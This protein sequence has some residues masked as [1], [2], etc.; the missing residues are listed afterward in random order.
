MRLIDKARDSF[1]GARIGASEGA[2]KL[3]IQADMAEES[4]I[5][6]QEGAGMPEVGSQDPLVSKFSRVF[7]SAFAELEL[8]F[9]DRGWR[10]VGASSFQFTRQTLASIIGLSR[11]MYLINPLIKRVVTVQ[12]LYVWGRGVKIKAE[13]PIVQET[14]DDFFKDPKNQCIIGDS[15]PERER[16]QRI[17]GTTYFVFYRNKVNGRARVRLIPVDQISRV[18][19]NP[20]DI[21]EPWFYVRVAN[22]T[23][24]GFLSDT[25]AA[26]E[27]AVSQETWYPDWNYNPNNQPR[28]APNGAKIAWDTTTYCLKTGGLSMMQFGLP[29]LF[30][31]FNWA[32]GYKKI[33]ENFATIL[34]SYARMALAISGLPG[35]AGV[36]ASKNK[37][38]TGVQGGGRALDNNPPTNTASWALISGAVDVKPIKTA[39]S[40]TGPDEARALRSMVAAGSDT[41]EHFLGDSDIGNFAT[42]STLDRPTELKMVS[43]QNMWANVCHMFSQRL[44]QWS[45]LAPGGKLRKAGYKAQ[46]ERDP[47]DGSVMITVTAPAD[48]STVVN[49]E[50]PNILERDVTDRVRAVV[51][52][53]TLNGSPAEGIIPDRKVVCRLLLEALGE[54]EAERMTDLLYPQPVVQGFQDPADRAD[55]E[56]LI[57]QGRKE[58]G[59]AAIIAANAAKTTANKPTPK[60]SG[61]PLAGGRR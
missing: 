55:D 57:A 29:E 36:A 60:P 35:K 51:A 21:K 54:E 27:P 18:I 41:P 19:T 23:P 6:S 30:S 38:K 42:S 13:T 1:I 10:G 52:A 33:L 46:K 53:V 11:V 20:E 44:I 43:R 61:S 39:G 59:D 50:F 37:L 58:L 5:Q 4:L 9:E 8:A 3:L 48:S 56:A 34:A 24:S 12:E 28:K 16:E 32:T 22:V 49:V 31:A 40:T 26:T 7:E 2:N 47:F 25:N 15:W 45:A 17:D 14:L